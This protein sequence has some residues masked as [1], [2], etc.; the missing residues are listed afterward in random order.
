MERELGNKPIC[1]LIV[2]D[3][4]TF[5]RIV[6]H[7]FQKFQEREFQLIWKESVEEA[8]REVRTNADIDIIVTDYNL[9]TT[10]GLEFV[11]QLN[12]M[13][14]QVP[15][16]FVTGTRD[17]KL[18]VDAMKLGVE[19]FLV[20]EDLQETHL[21]RTI[22]NVLERVQMRKQLRAVEKRMQIAEN[23]AQAIRELVV[24]VCHEFN[25]PLAAI[26]I[27][28]DLLQRMLTSNESSVL[29]KSF[30]KNFQK[31][32]LE[33]KRLRDINFEK[34]NFHEDQTAHS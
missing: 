2:D 30:E 6:E 25:N 4:S 26:K 10:N 28:A 24:T 29:L 19:D 20:K 23:R 5:V 27:S 32:E 9:P 18:A 11:L 13:D 31:I 7:H 33:I 17:Y 3:E 8:L 1:V 21:P 14:C 16:V 15:I 22:I 12:Q 34:I